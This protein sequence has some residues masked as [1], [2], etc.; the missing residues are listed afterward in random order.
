[1]KTKNPSRLR[2]EES[3]NLAEKLVYKHRGADYNKKINPY[4]KDFDH[5]RFER[6]YV[7]QREKYLFNCHEFKDMCEMH[8]F[9]INSLKEN[10]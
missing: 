4:K 7:Q 10:E 2:R 3:W 5:M 8:G 1:M 9:D 6:F